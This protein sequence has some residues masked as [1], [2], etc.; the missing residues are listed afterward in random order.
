MLITALLLPGAYAIEPE[1]AADERGFFAR[2]WCAREFQARGLK[3]DFVQSSLSSNRRRGTLRGLHYQLP[4]HA[5]RKLVRCIRGAAYDVIVDLR[6]E[7]PTYLS[8]HACELTAENGR[9]VYIPEGVAHGFQTLV[10]DT[11]LLYEITPFHSPAHSTGVR[12]NDG[13]LNI[14]WPLPQNPILSERD[15]NLP[16]LAQEAMWT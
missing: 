6:P 5:E 2:L 11:E 14:R 9:A 10:D 7:S 4:P 1:P 3:T 15:A 16:I 13:Q 12:W 8:W